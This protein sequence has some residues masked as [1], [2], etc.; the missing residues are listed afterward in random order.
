MDL[1]VHAELA[2]APRN[3]LGVL[4]AEIQD[5]DAVGVDVALCGRFCAGAG[6]GTWEARH[7]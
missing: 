6:R 2:H 7:A 5:E 4:R 3:Q 1:A